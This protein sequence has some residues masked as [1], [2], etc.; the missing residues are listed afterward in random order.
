MLKPLHVKKTEKDV[1]LGV[2]VQAPRIKKPLTKTVEKI[3]EY[4][5]I[6]RVTTIVDPAGRD[7]R[8]HF[9]KLTFVSASNMTG[10][11]P[12]GD[13]P[14]VKFNEHSPEFRNQLAQAAEVRA[15]EPHLANVIQIAPPPVEVAV[16]PSVEVAVERP[17][18]VAIDPPVEVAVSTDVDAMHPR[19]PQRVRKQKTQEKESDPTPLHISKSAK[20]IFGATLRKKAGL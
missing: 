11:K 20:H 9:R 8:C 2:Y 14:V 16:E 7:D 6:S 4:G 5:E 15:K 1:V 3:N 12:G 17:V 19:Y 13:I 10:L 18:E